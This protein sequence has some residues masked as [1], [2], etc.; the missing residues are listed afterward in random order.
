MDI[1]KRDKENDNSK[2]IGNREKE[3]QRMLDTER[4]KIKKGVI[5]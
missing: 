1:E 4:T 5:N 3:K 2:S